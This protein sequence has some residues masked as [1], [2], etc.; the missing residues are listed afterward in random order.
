M[1]GKVSP[2]TPLAGLI[3]VGLVGAVVC[4]VA[5]LLV[6]GRYN[7]D[8]LDPDTIAYMRLAWYYT[9]GQLHLAVSGYWGPLLSWLMV[10]WIDSLEDLVDA[11][12]IAMDLS[13]VVFVVGCVSIFRS[14]RLSPV[15]LLAGTWLVALATV[16]WSMELISPDLLV[17]GL[18]ALALGQMLHVRWCTSRLT[19]WLTGVL[20]GLAYLAKAIA[21]PV[22]VSCCLGVGGLWAFSHR[23]P[24]CQVR[25]SIGLTFLGCALVAGPWIAVLSWKYGTPTFSTSGAIAHAT[26]GPADVERYHHFRRMFHQPETGRLFSFEDPSV[27]PYHYWSPLANP[28]YAKHQLS[29][30]YANY[31]R[32]LRILQDFDTLGIG[33]FALVGGVLIPGSLRRRLRV[34]PWRWAIVPVVC[35]AGWY[36]PVYAMDQRYYFLAYPLLLAASMGLV[37]SL[38]QHLRRWRRGAWCVGVLLVVSSFAFPVL[39]KLPKALRGLETP[40][41]AAHRLS[42]KLRAAHISGPLAGIGTKEGLYIAFFMNQ[43]WYGEER[44]PTLERIKAAPATLYVMPRHSPLFALLDEDATFRNLDALLFT[45]VEE[46]QRYPWRVYQRLAP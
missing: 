9:T 42:T 23:R 7:R 29:L 8:V 38:S 14:L 2:T 11:A 36:L 6:A 39:T 5:L 10:P 33:L 26:V 34:E 16:F 17:S 21:L 3:R 12:R 46:A 30:I 15:A 4:Q 44:Q 20:C 41:V 27:M 22:T 19:P 32:Q 45:S 18:F 40:G 43:P 25:R 13:A 1:V 37:D 35:L 31:H 24:W 28:S